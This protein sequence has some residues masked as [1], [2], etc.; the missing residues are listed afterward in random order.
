VAAPAADQTLTSPAPTDTQT[1]PQNEL[2]LDGFTMFLMG[3]DNTAFSESNNA[4]WQD[5]KQPISEYYI[6]SSHNTYL[7]GHQLVGVSTIEGYIRALLHSCRS[8]EC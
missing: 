4:I 6:S 7:V 8:V 5:M 1:N 2:A 3:P